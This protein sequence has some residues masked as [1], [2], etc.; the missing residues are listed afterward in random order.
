MDLFVVSVTDYITYCG[1]NF[2]DNK[3][4]MK[5]GE[6][7]TYAEKLKCLL[8]SIGKS[9]HHNSSIEVKEIKRDIKGAHYK[10]TN[11]NP[12]NYPKIPKPCTYEN[13][14]EDCFIDELY[15]ELLQGKVR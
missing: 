7:M 5:E 3:V 12:M 9:R 10:I 2:L 4:R 11:N 13:Y 8:E 1:G 15:N 14:F 6:S